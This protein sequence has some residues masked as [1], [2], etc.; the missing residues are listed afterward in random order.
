M[1]RFF[2]SLLPL[3]LVF[4]LAPAASA[5]LDLPKTKDGA[6]IKKVEPQVA[7]AGGLVPHLECTTCGASNYTTSIGPKAKKGKQ[8]AW[9][10]HCRNVRLFRKVSPKDARSGG[11]LDLPD[12]GKSKEPVN[13]PGGA[14]TTQPERPTGTGP[15]PDTGATGV[16]HGILDEVLRQ[17]LT[18]LALVHTA[19]EGLVA[20]GDAGL[21]AARERLDTKDGSV[22]LV[23]TRTLL[24]GGVP[25]DAELVANRLRTDVPPKVGRALVEQLIQLNPVQAN[26]RLLCTLLD[27]PQKPVRVAA[28][29]K[30][31]SDGDGQR[32]FPASWLPH[33]QPVLV[34]KRMD[35]RLRALELLAGIDD[36]SVTE[37]VLDALADTRGR[38]A[39]KAVDILVT[40]DDD[41]VDVQLQMRAFGSRWILRENAYAIL[42]LVER[43]DRYFEPR[44]HAGHVETLLKAMEMSDPLVHH[45][46]ALALAGIGYRMERAED[47]P[48]LDGKVTEALVDVA[49]GV[50]FFDDRSSIQAPCVRRLQTLTGQGFGS[51]GP[52]WA[53]WWLR[54]RNGFRA[55]RAAMAWTAESYQN[56]RVRHVDR[57]AGTAVEFLGPAR[58]LQRQESFDG[59]RYYLSADQAMEFMA[60]MEERGVLGATRAP[61]PRGSDFA[62]GQELSVHLDGQAKT[63]TFGATVQEDWMQA[64]GTFL[65]AMQEQNHWQDFHL[66]SHGGKAGWVLQMREDP[67]GLPPEGL[68]RGRWMRG[69][70]LIWLTSRRGRSLTAGLDELKRLDA[71]G[72]G[73]DAMDFDPLLELLHAPVSFGDEGQTL[74]DLTLGAT[75]LKADGPATEEALLLGERLIGRLMERFGMDAVDTIANLLTLM[76]DERL[77][78][79]CA[80]DS[81]ILRVA[82]AMVNLDRGTP[83]S[84][85]FVEPM[86]TDAS[87]IVREK[88]LETCGL[89]GEQRALPAALLQALDGDVKTRQVAMRALGR[90][91]G[92]RSREVLQLMLVEPSSEFRLT[93]VEALAD[94]KD[95]KVAPILIALL[96]QG[97]EQGIHGALRRG[98]LDLGPGGQSSLRGS[99]G[100]PHP[101]VRR[102][103]AL[104]LGLQDVAR[105]APA[106][107]RILTEDPTDTQV[108]QVL[109][110]LTCVNL[111]NEDERA[112]AW[113]NWFDSVIQE[114]SFSWFLA[115]CSA[116]G[117]NPPMPFTE[118]FDVPTG[119]QRQPGINPENSSLSHDAMVF[120]T[121]AVQFTDAWLAERAY[122]EL[123]RRTGRDLGDMPRNL[124]ARQE[125]AEALLDDPVEIR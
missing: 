53:K 40:W 4:L 49:A 88:V 55:S 118:H 120:M 103:C 74:A 57:G 64:L 15:V 11:G 16:A 70:A 69:V 9:C 3:A 54:N 28:Y 33:L 1:S 107:M 46:A 24:L 52:E 125:W 17:R 89:K 37:R 30:L 105:A 42:A 86:L 117:L 78:L 41:A 59:E 90:L 102:E 72:M 39:R 68:R 110:G 44:L 71:Q 92:D 96:R 94:L 123:A 80:D 48:W 25:E 82:G 27:H 111:Q 34:S 50:H 7:R 67:D 26:P 21:V 22:L 14:E 112:E 18:D 63:F 29:K 6:P 81:A 51:S 97:K 101:V 31:M 12:L 20:S 122:R 115:A 73:P 60:W 8:K 47:S 99:L 19:A 100:S 108:A 32:A 56:L 10:S 79:A 119:L 45:T 5:Q 65:D 95:P 114:D 121:Q 113:W 83:E 84:W 43:E 76:G 77:R 38:V 85:L 61:G 23:V 93:A 124:R 66:P 62:R 75:G 35:S 2:A 109:V 106:L 98:L 36:P 104:I 87:T 13:L 116:R 91:G 58:L